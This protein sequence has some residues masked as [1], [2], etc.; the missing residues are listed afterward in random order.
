MFYEFIRLQRGAPLEITKGCKMLM[1]S[2]E[3]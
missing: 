2:I 3:L 1:V